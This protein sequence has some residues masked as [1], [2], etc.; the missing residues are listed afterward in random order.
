MPINEDN[1]EPHLCIH[2][3]DEWVELTN[4]FDINHPTTSLDGAHYVDEDSQLLQSS[5]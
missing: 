4:F 3:G 1:S 2:N 5:I